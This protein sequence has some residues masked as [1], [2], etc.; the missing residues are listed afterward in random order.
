M[1]PPLVSVITP[2][3][4]AA[5]FVGETIASVLAQTHGAVEHILVDDAS[6][7]G[8]WAIL[9]GFAGLHPARIRAIRLPANLGGSHAR[10]RG[11][12]D[13]RGDY[14]MFLDADDLIA[15]GT[16][17]ALVA[18]VK[19]RP[20]SL[21]VC[22]WRRLKRVNGAWT[23]APADAPLPPESSDAALRGWLDGSAWVPPCAL[24]WRRDAYQATGGWDET[25]TL[26]DD[27][28]L[29]MRALAGGAGVVRAAGGE[30]FYRWHDAARVSVSQSFLKAD[31]VRSQI[32]VLDKLAGILRAQ[33]R[34]AEFG[35]ALGRGYAGAAYLGFQNRHPE[36]GREAAAKARALAGRV[37]VSPRAGGRVLE[38]ILGLE[39][40]ERWVQRLAGLGMMTAQ[41]RRIVRLREVQARDEGG[42]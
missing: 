11:V 5:E 7:D 30:A 42:K 22:G 15:P 1:R 2:C 36:L 41:R 28:D 6:S 9:A 3:H 34:S 14:L 29:A 32:H 17:A 33:G 10:N 40:K 18:A 24:L 26:N 38:A 35:A 31:R 19:E 21:A 27:G 20:N 4:N 8:S 37:L 13:A 12:E 25:L 23:P 39:R 16:L